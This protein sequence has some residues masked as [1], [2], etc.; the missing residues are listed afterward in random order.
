VAQQRVELE[1]VRHRLD[2]TQVV[3]GDDLV[4]GAALEVG[5]QEVTADAAEPV[6]RDACHRHPPGA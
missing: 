5:A 3:D 2:V 6:D 4:V 1:Q